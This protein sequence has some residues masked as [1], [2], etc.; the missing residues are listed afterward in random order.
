MNGLRYWLHRRRMERHLLLEIDA[1]RRIMRPSPKDSRAEW[2]VLIVCIV[3]IVVALG[4]TWARAEP[5]CPRPW[6]CGQ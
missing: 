4:L 5:E 2:L 1:R 3:G 6:V